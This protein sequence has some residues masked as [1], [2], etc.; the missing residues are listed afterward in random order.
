M[1]RIYGKGASKGITEGT[2][3]FFRRSEPLIEKNMR[4]TPRRSWHALRLRGSL[5]CSSC[6]RCTIRFWSR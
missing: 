6:P 4:R 2:L 3:Y 1:I 5:P